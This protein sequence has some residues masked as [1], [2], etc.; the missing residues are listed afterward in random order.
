MDQLFAL[1]HVYSGAQIL[2][3]V[4]L[5]MTGGY[6]ADTFVF[7]LDYPKGKHNTATITDFEARAVHRRGSGDSPLVARGAP[8]RN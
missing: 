8:S 4:E 1:G 3:A 6:G 5:T 7:N 2:A